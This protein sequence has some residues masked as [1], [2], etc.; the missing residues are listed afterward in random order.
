MN[1]NQVSSLEGLEKCTALHTLSLRD[2][3]IQHL[4]GLAALPNLQVLSLDI[5]SITSLQGLG[6]CHGVRQLSVCSN[7]LASLSG[8]EAL[9][10]LERLSASAN[11]ITSLGAR[12]H[13]TLMAFAGVTVIVFVF[14][15]NL[16]LCGSTTTSAKPVCRCISSSD[17]ADSACDLSSS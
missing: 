14:Q 9:A 17:S 4:G 1:V 2:N 8:L 3:A 6:S 12:Q 15:S 10:S 16:R 13:A 11:Q 7:R 5:N